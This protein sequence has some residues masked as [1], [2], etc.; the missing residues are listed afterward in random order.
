[1][2]NPLPFSRGTSQISSAQLGI[3]V[4]FVSLSMLFGG[5]LVAFL[6]VRL[7][8]TDWRGGLPG[9]PL[10]MGA[11]TALLLGVSG[12]MHWALAAVRE[13]RVQTLLKA[14]R[15]GLCFAGAFLFVQ[16]I[17]WR[18]MSAAEMAPHGSTLYPF[19]FFMLTGLHAAHVV[20]GLVP[21]LVV[22]RRASEQAYS[23]S[24]HQGVRFCAQ[25]WDYLGVVWIVLTLALWA[26]T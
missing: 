4:L 21:H 6:W 17:N 20:F 19:T 2:S 24:Q 12:S 25:Y 18:A 23:S 15:L 14:L 3:V 26:F 13:N 1:M 22:M 11:C 7:T 16:A 5:A 9:L 8:N 10:G